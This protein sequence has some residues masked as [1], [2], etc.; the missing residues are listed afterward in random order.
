MRQVTIIAS[1]P[2]AED[3]M[4]FCIDQLAEKA[5]SIEIKVLPKNTTKHDLDRYIMDSMADVF[6][7]ASSRAHTLS[8]F[9]AESTNRPIVGVSLDV[10]EDPLDLYNFTEPP[11]GTG[12]VT[13]PINDISCTANLALR[14]LELERAHDVMETAMA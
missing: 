11:K 3:K 12:F 2:A 7:V 9:A 14:F 1:S 13:V 4:L 8:S 10:V 6:I 5:E